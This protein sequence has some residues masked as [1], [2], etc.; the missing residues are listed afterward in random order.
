MIKIAK[1]HEWA[2]LEDGIVSVGITPYAV[3]ALGDV[4]YI[5]LPEVGDTVTGGDT[6]GEVESVKA[7]SEL[8]APC[9]GEVVEVNTDLEDDFDVLKADATGAGWMIKI[10]AADPSQLDRLMTEAEYA[11]F[12]KSEE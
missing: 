1:S 12:V 10:K 3:E 2:R 5:E 6:F 9:T 4:V 11:E 7:A 8:F